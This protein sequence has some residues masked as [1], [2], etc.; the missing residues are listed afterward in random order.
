MRRTSQAKCRSQT[1][2]ARALKGAEGLRQIQENQE[3]DRESAAIP[4][5]S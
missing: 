2:R 5:F 3:S 1:Y 4:T